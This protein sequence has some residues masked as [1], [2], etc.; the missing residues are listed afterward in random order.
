M[1]GGGGVLLIKTEPCQDNATA[2]LSLEWFVVAPHSA[3]VP[4]GLTEN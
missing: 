2:K 3:A 1:L 4:L